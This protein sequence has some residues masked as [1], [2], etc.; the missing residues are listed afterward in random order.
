VIV[1]AVAF[2]VACGSGGSDGAKATPSP[3]NDAQAI[4][5]VDFTKNADVI[6]TLRQ[7]PGGSL[8]PKEIVYGDVTGDRREEAIVPVSSQG[9]LGN[10]AYLVFTMKGNSATLVLTR[11]LG[12]GS[13][14][15]SMKLD[16][17]KLVELTPELGPEDPLCCPSAMRKTTFRWDGAKLQV[18]REEKIEGA[19]QKKG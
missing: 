9:T 8:L 2:S 19:G 3:P 12:G 18:E 1:L 4:R 5:Q 15:I 6:T 16:E 13:G 17:G 10:L 7:L 14:G 11:G